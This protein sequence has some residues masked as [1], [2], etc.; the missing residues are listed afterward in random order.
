MEKPKYDFTGM[1]TRWPSD[2]V[3]REKV[4]DFTGG[5]IAAGSMANI[6]S[7]PERQGPPR[8]RF[9][10]KIAYPVREY[11]AWLNK[12]FSGVEAKQ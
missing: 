11:V 1:L 2:F 10:R 3:A 9:G 4:E 7:D 5:L 8:V 6:D 12:R